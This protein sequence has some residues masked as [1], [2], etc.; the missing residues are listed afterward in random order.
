MSRKFTWVAR[1]KREIQGQLDWMLMIPYL[2]KT[3]LAKLLRSV[4]ARVRGEASRPR[5]RGL[6]S[7]K[8]TPRPKPSAPAFGFA[9]PSEQQQRR[10]RPTDEL[11]PRLRGIH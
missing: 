11:E 6:L 2:M 1:S 3:L 4:T 9:P 10:G 7:V 5:C 8:R